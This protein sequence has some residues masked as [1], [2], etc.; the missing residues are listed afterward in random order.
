MRT[1]SAPYLCALAKLGRGDVALRVDVVA[2]R[3]AREVRHGVALEAYKRSCEDV[4]EEMMRAKR[5]VPA[6]PVKFIHIQ[7]RKMRAHIHE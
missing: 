7:G 1:F 6:L 3:E 5:T 2:K 4:D